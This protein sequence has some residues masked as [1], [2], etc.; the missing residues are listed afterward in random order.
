MALLNIVVYAKIPCFNLN[1]LSKELEIDFEEL[2][3]IIRILDKAKIL[4]M[5]RVIESDLS[6]NANHFIS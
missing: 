6:K 4:K 3:E 1:Y 2:L 5:I